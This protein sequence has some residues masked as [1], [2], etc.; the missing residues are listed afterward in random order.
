MA[1]QAYRASVF[2]LLGDPASGPPPLLVSGRWVTD[3]GRQE[4]AFVKL[5]LA[6]ASPSAVIGSPTP[7]N[8]MLRT[9]R[10]E[11][12]SGSCP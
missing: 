12:R 5:P 7:Q 6:G 4:V 2:H 8:Q 1:R 11:C 9:L 3:C 10:T